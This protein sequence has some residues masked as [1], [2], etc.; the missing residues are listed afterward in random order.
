[1][2]L[3]RRLL[4]HIVVFLTVFKTYIL[5]VHIA[6]TV[7][8]S[9]SRVSLLCAPDTP[10]TVLATTWRDLKRVAYFGLHFQKF[11]SMVIWALVLASVPRQSVRRTA[12]LLQGQEAAGVFLP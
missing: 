3:Q 4:G 12:C 2:T 7:D 9:A 6:P 5:F 1:M 10:S 8:I 11:E